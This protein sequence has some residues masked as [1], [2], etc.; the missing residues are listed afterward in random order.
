MNILL[1]FVDCQRD[2]INVDGALPVPGAPEILGNLRRLRAI[3]ST[4][5]KRVIYTQDFHSMDDTEISDKPNFTITFP[6]HC[7]GGTIGSSFVP[8]VCGCD[9]NMA[10]ITPECDLADML[11]TNEDLDILDNDI[12]FTKHVF[13][14]FDGNKNIETY[15][16]A[17]APDIV[18]VCGVAGDVCVKAVVNG[19]LDMN[20]LLEDL[21]S[22]EQIKICVVKDAV[23][24]LN[25]E[26]EKEFYDSLKNNSNTYVVD[27][28]FVE[29]FLSITNGMRET[30]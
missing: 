6:P 12:V 22:D 25:I 19:L 14:T 1:I 20:Q 2:F 10:F 29:N 16:E 18:F 4:F 15:I 5:N 8:E 30:V 23:K 7:I 21:N 17:T 9:D 13:S 26:S 3:A 11:M 28:N 27:T 24:S